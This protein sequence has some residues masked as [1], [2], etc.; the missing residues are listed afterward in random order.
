MSLSGDTL[1]RV[2]EFTT[3]LDDRKDLRA[4]GFL[5]ELD[6]IRGVYYCVLKKQG[7][8]MIDFFSSRRKP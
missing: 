3:I 8:I 7:L 2:L 1:G 6:G 5:I 4:Y